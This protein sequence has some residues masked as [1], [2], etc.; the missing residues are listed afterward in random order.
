MIQT[1]GK[2]NCGTHIVMATSARAGNRLYT[3]LLAGMQCLIK[4]VFVSV[5]VTDYSCRTA[6]VFGGYV[7]SALVLVSSRR[8]RLN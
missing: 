1:S 5:D 8:E 3:E 2:D 6:I 7:D 4:S